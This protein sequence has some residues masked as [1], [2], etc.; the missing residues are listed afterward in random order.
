MTS[1]VWRS[2]VFQG[3]VAAYPP[4]FQLSTKYASS[5]LKAPAFLRNTTQA[6]Y[7]HFLSTLTFLPSHILTLSTHNPSPPSPASAATPSKHSPNAR[8]KNLHTSS[9]SPSHA[10]NAIKPSIFNL[11]QARPNQILPAS[12]IDQTPRTSVLFHDHL[13]QNLQRRD[14]SDANQLGLHADVQRVAAFCNPF[15]VA[16]VVAA[17]R[18]A[19]ELGGFRAGRGLSGCCLG[20]HTCILQCRGCGAG[21][22][23]GRGRRVGGG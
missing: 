5:I 20:W 23:W 4:P 6:T 14:Q 22:L 12:H 9:P 13:I 15:L 19:A 16:G 11:P 18:G 2:P 21:G 1:H 10:P 8:S 7:S 17:V 3:W